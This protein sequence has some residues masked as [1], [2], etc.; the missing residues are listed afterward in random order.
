MTESP[1]L[2]AAVAIAAAAVLIFLIHRAFPSLTLKAAVADARADVTKA[3]TALSALGSN[4]EAYSH[5]ELVKLVGLIMDHIADTSTAQSQIK[6][7]QATMASQAQFLVAVQAR[8][9]A[10]HISAAG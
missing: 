2:L 7:G 4:L 6:S 5:A 10:A 3:E 8:V 1:F 9:A